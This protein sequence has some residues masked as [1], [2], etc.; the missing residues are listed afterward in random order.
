VGNPPAEPASQEQAAEK[1]KTKRTM[2]I[3]Q[4]VFNRPNCKSC[5]SG[6]Q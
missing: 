4:T 6:I 5:L 3:Q 1:P 2:G